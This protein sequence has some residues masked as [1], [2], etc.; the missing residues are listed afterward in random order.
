LLLAW[1]ES[2]E[3][4]G[5]GCLFLNALL[6]AIYAA[7]AAVLLWVAAAILMIPVFLVGAL[8]RAERLRD[9][10]SWWWFL[11]FDVADRWPP[12]IQWFLALAALVLATYGGFALLAW[13]F[14]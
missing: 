8:F 6:A 2:P 4:E 5:L 13:L 3:C 10:A 14:D 9:A 1:F 7:F 12:I 11:P